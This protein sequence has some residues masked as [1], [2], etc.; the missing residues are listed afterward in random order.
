MLEVTDELNGPINK[1]G[2]RFKQFLEDKAPEFS[3]HLAREKV[4]A[5]KYED[6][7][8]RTPWAVMLLAGL[9]QVIPNKDLK[10]V[11]VHAVQEAN[12]K[13]GKFIWH[14]FSNYSHQKEVLKHW[15]SAVLDIKPEIDLS[16]DLSEVSHRRVLSLTMETGKELKLAFD[17]GMGYWNSSDLPY[18]LRL[19]DFEAEGAE[20]A[21]QMMDVWKKTH[22]VNSEKW[23]TDI[24]VYQ[25]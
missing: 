2:S 24:A 15:L 21:Q 22:L 9:M 17:Q 16:S 1:L 5:I 11:S 13:P 19:H 7:Y 18:E 20:Q 6:R 14:N 3:A 8:L 23:A 4:T 10:S 12:P 25:V